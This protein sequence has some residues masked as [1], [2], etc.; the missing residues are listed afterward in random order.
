M[1]LSFDFIVHEC[2]L[3]RFAD[4]RRAFSDGDAGGL[5]RGDLIRRGSFSSGNNC[6]GMAHAPAGW[7]GAAR[8]ESHHGLLDVSLDKSRGLFFRQSADLSNHHDA[9]GVRVIIEKAQRVD[10]C[11]ADNRVAADSDAGGLTDRPAR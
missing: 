10:E 2:L 4:Q 9:V 3:Q 8:D 1:Q 11:C 7:R 5:K 6:S